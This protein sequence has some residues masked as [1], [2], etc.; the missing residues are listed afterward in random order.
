MEG[1]QPKKLGIHF[2]PPTLIL[3]YKTQSN[4]KKLSMPIRELSVT[5]DCSVLASRLQGRHKKQLSSV[6]IIAIEKMIRLIQEVI[7]G[8]DKSAA[9][10]IVSK[11]YLLN[12]DEDL[13][14]LNDK[15]LKRRKAIMDLNFKKNNIDKD[16]PDFVY[17]KEVD[18]SGEKKT[19]GWDSETSDDEGDSTPRPI[20]KT[21]DKNDDFENGELYPVQKSP[22]PPINSGVELDE[23]NSVSSNDSFKE[24]DNQKNTSTPSK[25]N[26]KPLQAEFLSGLTESLNPPLATNLAPIGLNKP[27]SSGSLNSLGP[28]AGLTGKPRSLL[29]P[30]PVLGKLSSAP[31]LHKALPP[32]DLKGVNSMAPKATLEPVPIVDIK[33]DAKSDENEHNKSDDES[34]SDDSELLPAVNVKMSP[35]KKLFGLIDSDEE[36]PQNKNGAKT[37]ADPEKLGAKTLVEEEISPRSI[38]QGDVSNNEE[39]DFW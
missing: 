20:S 18:F 12:P 30:L 14:R 25:E 7:K 38:S 29:D 24:E 27:E 28:P 35:T 31:P 19:S 10:E 1:V 5:S 22:A 36:N 8:H 34:F 23:N 9:L 39:E 11:E 4:Y 21:N 3:L 32:L 6:N 33:T 16:H 2:S 26:S 13:N 15:E 37:P 17:D